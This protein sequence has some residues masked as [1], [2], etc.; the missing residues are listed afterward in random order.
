MTAFAH[1]FNLRAV[2]FGGHTIPGMRRDGIPVLRVGSKDSVC[3]S[4]RGRL[5]LAVAGV[6]SLPQTSLPLSAWR[7]GFLAGV[8]SDCWGTMVN[9]LVVGAGILVE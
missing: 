2:Q 5:V 7:Q 4:Q 3:S 8:G 9:F 1:V 6:D